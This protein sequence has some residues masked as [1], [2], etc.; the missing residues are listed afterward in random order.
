M[1]RRTD[2]GGGYNSNPNLPLPEDQITLTADELKE[3]VRCTTDPIY[4]IK[5]YVKIISVD[6]GIIKFDLWPFQEEII[7]TFENNRFVICKLARQSG[8]S[9]VVVA[10]YF[11]W[12]ILF[13]ADVS[14]GVLANK[15]ATAIQL[16][17]RLKQSYE[18]L[19][20]FLKQGIIKWDA[21]VIKL[22][23]NARVR[24][25]STSASA[26]RGDTFNIIFLDE[27]AFVPENIALE[28]MTSVYP[29]ISSG[30]TSKLF[31]VSTPNGYNL[32]Y[33]IWN[34]A[35]EK[36]NT[37]VP[38]G[39]TW[40]DVP[41]RDEAWAE[42]TRKNLGSEQKFQQEFECDFMGSANTLIDPWKLAQLSYS[43]P[44]EER[45][46]HM[47]I[48][49]HP[50]YGNEDGPGHVYLITIDVGQGQKQDY[51]V[52][53]V[54]DISESP[55]VQVAIY[56]DNTIKP[57]QFASTIRDLGRY[58][59]NAFLFFEINAE[60]ASCASIVAEEF[61]Y[62]NIVHIFPHP[63]KGQQISGGFHK[64]ARQGLKVTEA[65]KRVGCTGL[66]SLIENNKLI[67]VDYETMR[68]LT[69]FVAKMAKNG[70]HAK[71]YE[72]E[73]GNHDDTI[74]AL[75]LLGWLTLQSGFENYVGLSMR[76]LLTDGHE[77]L[78]FDEPFIGILGDLS[79][80][81]APEKTPYGWE[82]VQDDSFWNDERP[83][84]PGDD[85]NEPTNR[86]WLM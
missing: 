65:T 16:L 31:I 8:K 48:Y 52:A 69:T 56:R 50:V 62:E 53:Q 42:E 55:F 79:N 4:F 1:A 71:T 70:S 54:I 26:I 81:P 63:K 36:R 61:E 23:N 86:N 74:S 28:F 37:Y 57:A 43:T 84:P 39:F 32:Y 80:G 9:T 85:D 49:K 29:T 6:E 15:E 38:I 76:K 45:G 13:H 5:K 7:N 27:F 35:V 33:K 82:V 72:A 60:G 12:Y 3:Y 75:V 44:I 51:S 17:D 21:K 20:R 24:A 78:T 58:Y 77:P 14:V 11:L 73:T 30:K 10:G 19:P 66:K 40:R 25:E 18:L 59:N 64:R 41:G 2:S 83:G 67:I 47:K 46:E 68:E 22:A 34:D